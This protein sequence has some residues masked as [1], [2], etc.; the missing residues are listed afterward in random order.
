MKRRSICL[1]LLALL[2]LCAAPSLRAQPVDSLIVQGKRL[3]AAGFN[4]TNVDKMLQARA[5]FER[6]TQ[7]AKRAALAHYYVGLAGNRIG[8]LLAPT[9]EDE[10][11]AHINQAIEHLEKATKLDQQFAEAFAMLSSVY[12][13]K[14]G[15]KPMLGMIMGP[16]ADVTLKK[17]KKLDPDNPR[18]T[19][20][21]AMSDFHKP[22][23]WGGSRERALDGLR[24]AADL[25]AQAKPAADPLLPDWGYDET[26]AWLGI[27]YMGEKQYDE[28]RQ[29]FT[30]ALEINPGFGW[31]KEY[32][33]P[34][35]DKEEA[36]S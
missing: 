6:A 21:E 3:L 9:D 26:Y 15:M 2:V 5:L 1:S 35:L 11:M 7:D 29:A 23:T 19:Y 10:A 4:E 12:G 28:A 17:A 34:A 25:F 36:G 20:L 24:H 13:R 8:N 31:V 18:I 30:K 33:L 32:L 27:G 22:A 14:I 16:K